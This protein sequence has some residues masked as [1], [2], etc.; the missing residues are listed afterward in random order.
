VDDLTE[1]VD[2]DGANE[3][4]NGET[5]VGMKGRTPNLPPARDAGNFTGS[6]ENEVSG[7]G[8]DLNGIALSKETNNA[9]I[10]ESPA[11][12]VPG[13]QNLGER[14]NSIRAAAFSTLNQDFGPEHLLLV[15]RDP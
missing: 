6:K 7:L 11:G 10:G 4:A 13:C 2:L 14:W 15:I 8:L 5:R 1:S 9:R 3:S 12:F